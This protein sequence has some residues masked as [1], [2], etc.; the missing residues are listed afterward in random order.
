MR[1]LVLTFA[2]LMLAG[3][4]RAAGESSPVTPPA[5]PSGLSQSKFLG[6]LYSEIAKRTPTVSPGPGSATASFHIDA[7]GKL[8][9]VTIAQAS[10]AKHGEIVRKILTGLQV[11]PPPTGSFEGS[12]K[13]N[14]H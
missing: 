6:L 8:D 3:A 5:P 11:P 10:S 2:L 7:S 1:R 13:F 14:F 4:A 12:Q 9:R